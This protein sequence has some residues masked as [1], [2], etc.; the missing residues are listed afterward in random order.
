MPPATWSAGSDTPSC[1]RIG[2]PNSAKASTIS[3]AMATAFSEMARRS[4]FVAFGVRE[5]TS[6]A[7]SIGPM[8]AKKVVKAV[9]AVSSM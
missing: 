7:E 1:V 4:A 6:T 3:V 5:A 9:S 2:C 8:T